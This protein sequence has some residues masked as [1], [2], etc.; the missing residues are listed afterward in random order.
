[1]TP[2]LQPTD[3]HP[4]LSTVTPGVRR[5]RGPLRRAIERWIS[6]S[7]AEPGDSGPAPDVDGA[8]CSGGRGVGRG[9]ARCQRDHAALSVVPDAARL[10]LDVITV[11]VGACVTGF[12]SRRAQLSGAGCARDHHAGIGGWTRHELLPGGRAGR[13]AGVGPEK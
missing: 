9:A 1:M 6:K 2:V 3:A 12:C 11:P 4:S 5:S 10:W 8:R 7:A 13:Q